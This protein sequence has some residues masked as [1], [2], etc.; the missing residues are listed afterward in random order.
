MLF[1]LAKLALDY[2]SVNQLVLAHLLLRLTWVTV[3]QLT[4]SV[5]AIVGSSSGALQAVMSRLALAQIVG[6]YYKSKIVGFNPG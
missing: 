5:S 4:M 1:Y 6:L 3:Q 2:P